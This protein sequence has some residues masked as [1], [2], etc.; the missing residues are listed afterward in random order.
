[1]FAFDNL[2]LSALNKNKAARI[3]EGTLLVRIMDLANGRLLHLPLHCDLIFFAKSLSPFAYSSAHI[4]LPIFFCFFAM[5]STEILN[6][7][8]FSSFEATRNNPI[9]GMTINKG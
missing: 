2:V 7:R 4:Y 3:M 8:R 6:F 9:S 1:M 5:L